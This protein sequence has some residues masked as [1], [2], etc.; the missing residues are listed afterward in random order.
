MGSYLL[1]VSER[2][3]IE[4]IKSALTELVHDAELQAAHHREFIPIGARA[5][6]GVRA[7][8]D[9][10]IQSGVAIGIAQAWEVIAEALGEM[11]QPL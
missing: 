1:L 5:A 10:A 9:A 3:D 6:E 7:G 8:F 4:K 2:P 11:P